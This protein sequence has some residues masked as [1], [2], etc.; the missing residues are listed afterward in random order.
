M[1]TSYSITVFLSLFYFSVL[2]QKTSTCD[3]PKEEAIIDLNTITK[4]S[5]KEDKADKTNSIVSR[6]SQRISIQISRKRIVRKDAATSNTLA[7]NH[8]IS[9][10]KR[11]AEA[12]KNLLDLNTGM[13]SKIP[14]D[15]IENKPL[16]A[17]CKDKPIKAQEDCFNKEIMKHVKEHFTYPPEAYRKG[18][19]GRVFAQFV[20]DEQG[21][22]TD[23]NMRGPYRGELLEDEAERIIK[24]LPKF[25]PGQ[26]NGQAVKVRYGVPISFRIPGKKPT[27]IRKKKKEV[28]LDDIVFFSTVEE[29]PLF[30]KCVNV[31][32]DE[33]LDCF[34]SQMM[35]HVQKYFEYPEIAVHNGI[36]GKVYVY[37]IID[38]E[39]DVINIESRGPNGGQVLNNMA[40]LVIGKL[41]QFIPGKQKGKAVN[42]KYV[43]PI[44]FKL[45]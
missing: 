25:I 22:V 33:K 23:L 21:S 8:S 5:V 29:I 12:L 2:S 26:Y 14:F 6:K 20:I 1:K 9:E 37:F 11:K 38:K 27:N 42:V 45:N 3:S 40:E 35:A 13:I 16:F 30:R 19:Q 39:G 10:V 4:C 15:L 7:N 17:S 44:N 31:V 41:P 24:R 34:N 18:I 36:E 43:I 32:K 28:A